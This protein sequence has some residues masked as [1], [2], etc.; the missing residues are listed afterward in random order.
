M[1]EHSFGV[2]FFSISQMFHVLDRLWS[3]VLMLVILQFLRMELFQP[4]PN[5]TAGRIIVTTSN[6]QKIR[7]GEPN[8]YILQ[9]S[10][11]KHKNTGA[12][13]AF[14]GFNCRGGL[15]H[16]F[17]LLAVASIDNYAILLKAYYDR[18][19]SEKIHRKYKQYVSVFTDTIVK[20]C[21]SSQG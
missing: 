18:K 4:S 8:C 12:Q 2:L 11:T 15:R 1:H 3:M 19:W 5:K 6:Q 9:V 16:Q 13:E 7:P 17:S 10:N 21:T 20:G 14:A